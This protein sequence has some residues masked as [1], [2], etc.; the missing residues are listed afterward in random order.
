MSNNFK[1]FDGLECFNGGEDIEEEIYSEDKEDIKYL[2]IYEK[3]EGVKLGLFYKRTKNSKIWWTNPD[4]MMGLHLFS[5]DR[6]KIYNFFSDWDE[7]TEEQKKIFGEEEPMLA[8]LK[9]YKG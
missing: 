2:E 5:F 3:E 4:D 1:Y 7:L 6:K 8:R 9:G